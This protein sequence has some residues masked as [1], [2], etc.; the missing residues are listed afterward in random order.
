MGNVIGIQISCDAIFSV[1]LSCTLKKAANVRQLE[2]NLLALETQLQK[3]I[4][5]K[6]DVLMR[7]LTAEQQRMRRLNQ[8]QG[9]LSRV[10]RAKREVDELMRH[11]SQEKAKLCLGGFCSKNCISSYKFGKE[12][13]KLLRDVENI[14]SEGAF[15]TVAERIPEAA[16]DE[17]NCDPTT[18]G[19]ES[20]FEEV[21]KSL[22]KESVGIIGIY[23][24]GGVGKTTLLTRIN[25]KFVKT[26]KPFDVVV[27]VV[28]S[29]DLRLEKIQHEIGKRIGLYNE[30]WTNR[31]FE[32]KADDIFKILS[33]KKFVLLLDDIW[34]RVDLIKVGVPLPS[35]KIKSKILFTTRFRDICG[36]IEADEKFK[37]ECLSEEKAWELFQKK[38]G[39]DT[40]NSHPDIPDLAQ[41]VA[42][43]CGGLPL[44]LK[45]VGRAMACRKTTE[46]WRYAIQLLRRSSA[47]FLG[48]EKEVYPLL[49]FSYDSLPSDK[50]RSCLLYCSLF[51]EDVSIQ[52]SR[53][54]DFWIGE[55][56]LD[57]T[58]SSGVRNQGYYIIGVLLRA[59]L[60]EEEGSYCVKMHD[61]IRDTALWIACEIEKEKENFLVRAGVGLREAP[62]IEK[63]EGVRR[64]SLMRN[65][66]GFLSEVP[67]CPNLLTLFLE[68][69]RLAMIN[70]DFFQSM[71][72]LRVLTLSRNRFLNEFP[73][74]IVR[75]VS[76]QS[77]EMSG[78]LIKKLPKELK[79]LVNLKCLN[80]EF[81]A[82]LHTIPRQVMS[83][84]T[85]LRVLRMFRGGMATSDE[86]AA[87]DNVLFGG[88]ESL[89]EELFS[90]KHLDM[91]T[92][93][94]KSSRALHRFSSARKFQICSRSISLQC[95][96][97]SK[98]LDISCLADLKNLDRLSVDD[99]ELLE[100]LKIGYTE[101]VQKARQPHAF[102]RLGSI[103]VRNCCKLR[104]LTWL[105][106][107]PKLTHVRIFD[108]SAME[109]IISVEKFSDYLET[110]RNVEPLAKLEYLHL[111]D[112]P[113]LKRIYW[114]PL[115]LTD[116]SVIRCPELKQLPLDSKSAGQR[117]I[118]I[119]GKEDWW[120]KLQWEN[121]ATQ[122]AFLPFF[123]AR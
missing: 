119:R 1:C 87:E 66:I 7:V 11:S 22:G 2:D 86:T 31:G 99:C 46:E 103:L 8:V 33:K 60:L 90:L 95:F 120:K 107:L 21:W 109:E 32:E 24:M 98:S 47:E 58:D 5:A 25:N 54:I 35:A 80:L 78:A 45:T 44:A 72:S 67:T 112:L 68:D 123:S 122:N 15:E 116:I 85:K 51:P 104:D 113:N 39:E 71:H 84:F 9:W 12:V 55:G 105:V 37:V 91:L 92:F 89:V 83:S 88:G 40:L 53:L 76:L 38:V 23:G 28:V 20:I 14:M 93:N 94:L 41:T 4:E 61:V 121:E 115:R 65:Q 82:A 10:E 102:H 43:E 110:M 101:E 114:K 74:G 59:C 18:V 63:W 29:R 48:M 30:S 49:K 77:L 27:S 13:A 96:D 100:E 97:D 81:T 111:E 50:I 56:F 19:M 57:D 36:L 118:R 16:V 6:D 73:F 17:I 42:K 79:S 62:E 106:F 52:K 70:R 64:V 69:N 75:L 108:C 3:L 34:E 26:P 117:K